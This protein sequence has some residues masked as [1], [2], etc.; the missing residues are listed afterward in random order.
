ML[1]SQFADDT[2]LCLDG[3][4][5]SFREAINTLKQF[6]QTSGLNV[7]DEKTQVV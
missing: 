2:S 5:E 1:L 3:S 6:C 4:E 7:N